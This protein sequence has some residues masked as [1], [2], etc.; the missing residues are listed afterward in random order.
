[1]G[2]KVSRMLRRVGNTVQQILGAAG[3]DSVGNMMRGVGNTASDRES[4]GGWY[5]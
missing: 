3:R 5:V 1:M 2:D 4:P